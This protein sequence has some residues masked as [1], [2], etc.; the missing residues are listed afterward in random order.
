MF[1]CQTAH[2]CLSS[3][4][5]F[6]LA[7]CIPNSLNNNYVVTSKQKKLRRNSILKAQIAKA[8]QLLQLG[9]DIC[10]SL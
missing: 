10:L 2:V 5:R 7:Y 3:L 9:G 4:K 8:C 1:S 6:T